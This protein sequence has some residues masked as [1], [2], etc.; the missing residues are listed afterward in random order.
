M[1][2][3]DRDHN[4]DTGIFQKNSCRCSIKGGGS[5]RSPSASILVNNINSELTG[6]QF[7]PSS[8][9]LLVRRQEGHPACNNVG[10][11]YVGG[12]DLTGALHVL[13]LQ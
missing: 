3:G 12:D 6:A 2:G 4:G 5:R 8:L 10:C 7:V 9:T 11:W 13:L 1:F